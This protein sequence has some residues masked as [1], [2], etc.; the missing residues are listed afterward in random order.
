[1]EQSF[2]IPRITQSISV[3]FG[4]SPHTLVDHHLL[5]AHYNLRDGVASGEAAPMIIQWCQ[6][7]DESVLYIMTRMIFPMVHMGGWVVR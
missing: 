2:T 4:C 6:S 7:T 1:M 3:N 5:W